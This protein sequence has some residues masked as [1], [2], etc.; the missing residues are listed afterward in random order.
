MS[1]RNKMYISSNNIR[2]LFSKVDSIRGSTSCPQLGSAACPCLSP[3]RRGW[4]SSVSW[5]SLALDNLRLG[6]VAASVVTD[7]L[8]HALAHSL[9]RLLKNISLLSSSSSAGTLDSVFLKIGLNLLSSGY[10]WWVKGLPWSRHCTPAWWRACT[11]G[12]RCPH[13]ESP[14]PCL[15]QSS[16]W[17]QT[18]GQGRGQTL[19]GISF[20]K[21]ETFSR[22][23][24]DWFFSSSSG[25][26]Q[27]LTQLSNLI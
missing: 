8:G 6:P 9:R 20:Y 5:A 17:G 24:T 12:S 26:Y 4:A 10:L 21:T 2:C 27:T 16:S 18:L 11:P 22:R 3:G 23:L 15:A 7:L 13:T 25:S 1:P 14:T 19:W